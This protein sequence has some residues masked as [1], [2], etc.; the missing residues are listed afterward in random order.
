MKF[1]GNAQRRLK[2]LSFHGAILYVFDLGLMSDCLKVPIQPEYRKNRPHRSFIQ[3][4]TI[5][6]QG[7]TQL[8][9]NLSTTNPLLSVTTIPEKYLNKI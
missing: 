4:I 1:S 8:F 7:L 2:K 3:N 5:T 6:K 9:S